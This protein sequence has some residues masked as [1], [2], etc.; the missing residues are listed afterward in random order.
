MKTVV[1]HSCCFIIQAD[2][3]LAGGVG[4]PQQS[5]MISQAPGR[6]A[7]NGSKGQRCIGKHLRHPRKMSSTSA[8]AWRK[9]NTLE[10]ALRMV[11]EDGPFLEMSSLAWGVYCATRCKQGWSAREHHNRQQG[12]QQQKEGTVQATITMS[13]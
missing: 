7:V 8:Q 13:K 9:A 5:C 10:R 6:H 4:S 3:L 1:M 12:S 2:A 11:I